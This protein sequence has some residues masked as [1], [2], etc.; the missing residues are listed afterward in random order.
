MRL[1]NKNA[2]ITGSANGIG[3]AIAE[4]FAKEGANVIVADIE[5]DAGLSTAENINKES[6]N[7]KY[8]KVDTSD[9]ASVQNMVQSG[10][11]MVQNRAKNMVQTLF[12]WSSN[13]GSNVAQNRSMC[14]LKLS[15]LPVCNCMIFPV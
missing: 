13:C 6:G 5:E 9:I 7:A 11:N 14:G 15:N 10:S 1:K 8:I 4:L 12:K 2:I 3:K